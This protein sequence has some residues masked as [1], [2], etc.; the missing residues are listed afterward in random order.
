M[1]PRCC[2]NH[3]GASA[4]L[5]GAPCSPPLPACGSLVWTIFLTGA[6]T[7]RLSKS[8][9][10]HCFHRQ[11]VKEGSRGSHALALT[12]SAEGHGSLAEARHM[13]TLEVTRPGASARSDA[14][15]VI[16]AVPSTNAGERSRLS[17][18]LWRHRSPWG[19][20]WRSAHVTTGVE[21]P[22][23]LG[24]DSH[25]GKQSSKATPCTL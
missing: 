12:V 8:P 5:E 13:D 25:R 10:Q 6:R 24:A 7:P 2:G 20:L 21:E 16:E 3:I 22:G 17:G 23:E 1:A 15:A 9:S 4:S 19:P 11:K 14:W 18:A